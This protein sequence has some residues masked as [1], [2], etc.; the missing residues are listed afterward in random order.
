MRETKYFVIFQFIYKVSRQK[1][2]D[3]G[4]LLSVQYTVDRDQCEKNCQNKFGEVGLF[5]KVFVFL[6]LNIYDCF[7]LSLRGVNLAKYNYI[8]GSVCSHG[9]RGDINRFSLS[10]SQRFHKSRYISLCKSLTKALFSQKL[11]YIFVCKLDRLDKIRQLCLKG[12]EKN[13]FIRTNCG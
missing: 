6:Y 4:P 3:L 13:A 5:V 7:P 10:S 11:S 12:I 8:F 9:K 1:P 2:S